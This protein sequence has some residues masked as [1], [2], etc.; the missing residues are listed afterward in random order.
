MLSAYWKLI[1]IIVMH[2]CNFNSLETFVIL[3]FGNF[4]NGTLYRT[5]KWYTVSE[6]E[7]SDYHTINC[8]INQPSYRKLCQCVANSWHQCSTSIE[9]QRL[10]QC[11]MY[12]T[13]LRWYKVVLIHTKM[14]DM[15]KLP[16][17]I[18]TNIW[19]VNLLSA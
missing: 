11:G 5:R 2:I 17:Y 12:E 14:H 6:A 8:F 1:I 18:L 16:L 3:W 15:S 13:E 10:L 4:E 7:L 19:L 9:L